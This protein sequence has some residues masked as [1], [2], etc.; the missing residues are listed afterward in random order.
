MVKVCV[1]QT[2]NRPHLHFLKLTKDINQ[3]FCSQLGYDYLFLPFDNSEFGNINPCTKKI[4]IIND[5]FLKNTEYDILVFLDS[6]AWIQNG[7]WLNDLLHDLEKNDN[8]HACFSRDPY[9]KKN[10]YINAGSFILK[11]NEFT[12]KM[13]QD[14]ICHLENDTTYHNGWPY[15]QYDISNYI[16]NNK[17]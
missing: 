12:K 2:D 13:Y 6:D 8:K 3:V 11:I 1:F 4:H 5:F 14:I 9:V 17:D 16:Y 10:T 15:D 7:E